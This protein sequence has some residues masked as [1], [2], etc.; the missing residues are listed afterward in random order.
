MIC[1]KSNLQDMI[2]K[3]SNLKIS[4]PSGATENFLS[5]HLGIMHSNP[6]IATACGWESRELN[7]PS[8]GRG[9]TLFFLSI[10]ATIGNFGR[11]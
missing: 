6:D 10:I 8:G 2:F 9:G 4:D 7:C 3:Q 11:S 5:Y 1:I